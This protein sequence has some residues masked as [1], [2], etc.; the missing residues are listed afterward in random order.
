[1]STPLIHYILIRRDISTGAAC[2]QIV[3]AAGESAAGFLWML[4]PRTIAVVLG[5]RDEKELRRYH[6]K[7]VKAEIPIFPIIENEGFLAGQMTAIGIVPIHDREKVRSVVKKLMPLS[8][9]GVD[10]DGFMTD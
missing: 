6:K 2:A 7:L 10:E 9:F 1:M 3:H 8:S 4:P 5:V